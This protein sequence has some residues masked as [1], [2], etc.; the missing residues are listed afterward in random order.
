MEVIYYLILGMLIIIYIKD[1]DALLTTLRT[2]LL[3]VQAILCSI[4]GD[5][6]GDQDNLELR[7]RIFKLTIIIVLIAWF[8]GAIIHRSSIDY[9]CIQYDYIILSSLGFLLSCIAGISGFEAQS[10]IGQ[11][12]EN[13]RI[14]M[15]QQLANRER[16]NQQIQFA[17]NNR[18]KILVLLSGGLITFTI[19]LIWDIW[20]HSQ[21]DSFSLMHRLLLWPFNN[22]SIYVISYESFIL[23]ILKFISL[24]SLQISVYFAFYH[25]NKDV[26]IKQQ[27]QELTQLG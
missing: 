13:Q 15:K 8:W 23:G 9:N 5:I 2:T 24:S 10:G 3:I 14:I 19:Q 25:M 11:Y 20:A 17:E 4:F 21:A 22:I 27:E 6:I 18:K 26:L 12:I 1:D 7:Q 16:I